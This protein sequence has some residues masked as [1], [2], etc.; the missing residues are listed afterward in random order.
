M[1]D[2]VAYMYVLACSDGT[3][4]TGYTTDIERRLKA[5]NSGKGAK[6]TKT[7]LPVTLLYHEPFESKQAAMKAEYAFKKKTR[8]QKL[9]FL[10]KDNSDFGVSL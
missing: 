9:D 5:H 6:Y 2:K 3:L 10:K 1:P 7:R 8:Q 4:Y